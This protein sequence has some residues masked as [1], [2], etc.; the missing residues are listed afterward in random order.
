[1]SYTTPPLKPIVGKNSYCGPA[2]IATIAGVT[3]DDAASIIRRRRLLRN[4]YATPV[5]GTYTSEVVHALDVLGFD[6]DLYQRINRGGRPTLAKWLRERKDRTATY[7][8][9]VTGHWLV[10]RGIK[11]ADSLHRE[12]VTIRQAKGRRCRVCA[13]HLIEKR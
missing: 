4:G 13:V 7:L 2:A 10:V 3:T 5:R 11:L 12:I 1:M 8:V 6:C 9:E